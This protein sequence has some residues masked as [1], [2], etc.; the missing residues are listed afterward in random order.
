MLEQYLFLLIL[1]L[2]KPARNEQLGCVNLWVLQHLRERLLT[3]NLLLTKTVWDVT[4][5][6]SLPKPIKLLVIITRPVM[7]I[8]KSHLCYS[9]CGSYLA[10]LAEGHRL[11]WSFFT[12]C[13]LSHIFVLCVPPDLREIVFVIQSQSNTFHVRQAE[14]RREDLLKQARGFTKVRLSVHAFFLWWYILV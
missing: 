12:V 9:G 11:P 10:L 5:T 1:Q 13:E 6:Y 2:C 14:R 7:D 3:A 4:F 8:S